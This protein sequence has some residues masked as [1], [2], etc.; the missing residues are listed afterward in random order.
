MK[1][2]TRASLLASAIQGLYFPSAGVSITAVAAGDFQTCAV[3]S[4]G[5]LWCWGFNNHGQLGINS[6]ADQH[7][8]V[9]V[10]LGTYGI[11]CIYVIYNTACRTCI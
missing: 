1:N 8:P 5:G 6:I 11:V 2:H 9:A 4:G 3:A 7:S 10:K